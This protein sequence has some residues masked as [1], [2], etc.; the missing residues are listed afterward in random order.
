MG[1]Y[2]YLTLTLPQQAG[3]GEINPL[4][5]KLPYGSGLLSFLSTIVNG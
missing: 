3:R 2:K 4:Q 5:F 1:K